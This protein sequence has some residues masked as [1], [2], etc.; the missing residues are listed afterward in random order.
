MSVQKCA[1]CEH[2]LQ[3]GDAVTAVVSSVYHSVPSTVLYA[4]ESPTQCHK[5]AHAFCITGDEVEL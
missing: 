5:L 1:V 3:D 4:I 2:L